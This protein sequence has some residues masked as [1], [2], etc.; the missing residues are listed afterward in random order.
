MILQ[1]NILFGPEILE[2]RSL[3]TLVEYFIRSSSSRN[4]GFEPNAACKVL[5]KSLVLNL[6]LY[7][8]SKF[9]QIPCSCS[10][11]KQIVQRFLVPTIVEHPIIGTVEVC[12][13]SAV[14]FLAT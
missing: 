9:W 4:S 3:I 12:I 2:T 6:L 10:S 7:E 13:S 14:M 1:K 8:F 11:T 5:T